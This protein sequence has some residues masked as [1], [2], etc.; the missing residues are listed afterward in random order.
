MIITPE[1]VEWFN[2][3]KGDFKRF[4]ELFPNGIEAN[5]DG[6]KQLEAANIS[7]RWFIREFKLTVK[8]EILTSSGKPWAVFYF[9]DGKQHD[10]IPATRFFYA[11]GTVRK[12]IHYIEGKII[13]ESTP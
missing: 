13:H 6:M 5:D 12:E 3:Y 10:P 2:P 1:M 11:D 4:K 7:S 8:L 9:K